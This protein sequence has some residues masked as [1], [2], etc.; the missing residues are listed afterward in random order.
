MNLRVV[1]LLYGF[2]VGRINT[3]LTKAFGACVTILQTA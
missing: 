2:C 3:S 1:P